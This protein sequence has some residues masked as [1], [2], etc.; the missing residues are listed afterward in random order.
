MNDSTLSTNDLFH[1]LEDR[2]VE[3]EQRIIKVYDRIDEMKKDLHEEIEKSH[4]EIMNS[5]SDMRQEMK[6]HTDEECEMLDKLDRRV[7]EIEKWRWFVIGGAAA[8]AFLV[9]G[10]LDQLLTFLQIK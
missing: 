5:I 7:A 9:F 10:G 2:R 3:E 1:I 4:T 8:V 6:R